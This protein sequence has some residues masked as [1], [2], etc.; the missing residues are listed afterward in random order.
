MTRPSSLLFLTILLP[1]FSIAQEDVVKAVM[2]DSVSISVKRGFD[3]EDFIRMVRE[4]TSF[5]KAFKNLKCLSNKSSSNL[6]VLNKESNEK[7]SFNRKATQHVANRRM[8]ITVDEEN[9]QG[10]LYKRNGEHRYYT[11]EM[12]DHI[13]F[14]KDTVRVSN[15][16]RSG[17]GEK[18]DGKNERNKDKLKLLIFNPGAEVGGVPLVGK[19][20]AIFDPK[21]VKYYN[22]RISKEMY[23]DTI[24]CYVFSCEAKPGKGEDKTV[25]KSLKSYFDRSTF[26]VVSRSYKLEY[27]SL[28]FDFNVNINVDLTTHA[29]FLVPEKIEYSGYW[30]VPLK[31]IESI[32]FISRFTDF[33]IE[34]Q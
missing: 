19:K 11:A 14:P 2:L 10:K 24:S 29:G 22:Y 8:W 33:K 21:M 18:Q 25:I 7:A 17:T 20:M 12:F 16:I 13:F 1:I 32:N 9:V 30:D 23:R 34:T 26:N 3:K 6:T 15:I 4:D 31:K 28:L 5:Y 27:T